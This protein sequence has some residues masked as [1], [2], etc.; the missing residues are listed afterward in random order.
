YSP[1]R[2]SYKDVF[3]L[4][5][6]ISFRESLLLVISMGGIVNVSI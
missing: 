1:N 6:K 4:T 3:Y 5:R 2:L